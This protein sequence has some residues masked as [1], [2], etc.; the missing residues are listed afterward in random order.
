[1][2]EV[3]PV[4]GAEAAVPEFDPAAA[5]RLLDAAGWTDSEPKD[6]II[7]RTLQ[8]IPSVVG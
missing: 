4:S 2:V 5:A 6:G 7:Q 1:M 8:T 3:G